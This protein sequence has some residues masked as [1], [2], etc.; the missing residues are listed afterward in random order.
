M[1]ARVP[2][3]RTTPGGM[4]F[5][6]AIAAVI[7]TLVASA[8]LSLGLVPG[9]PGAT[10]ARAATLAEIAADLRTDFVY[11]DYGAENAFTVSETANLALQI[12]DSGLPIFVAV[13]PQAA[14]DAAGGPDALLV[15]IKDAVGRSGVYAVLAGSSFRAG[16]TDVSV[17]ALAERAFADNRAA[18]P[19]A[20]VQAFVDDVIATYGTDSGSAAGSS[21]GSTGGSPIPALVILGVIAAIIGTIAVIAIRRGR[22]RRER[23]LE[24]LRPLLDE[25]ITALGERL[26]AFDTTDP[27]LDD[28]GRQDLQVA[29]DAYAS[30]S[31][32]ASRIRASTDVVAT[33]RSLDNGRYALSCVEARLA[34]APIP[35]RRA[36]CFFDPRHGVSL[37]D[38]RWEPPGG[39]AHPVPAC[40][41]CLVAVREGSQP[42][43]RE[44]E[45]DGAR[46][47]YWD[48]DAT[49]APYARGYF[50]DFQ[51]TMAGAFTGTLIAQ[52]LIGSAAAP[53]PAH[54]G[55]ATT[56]AATFGVGEGPSSGGSGGGDFGGGDFGG[57]F[58]GGGFG[59][60]DFGGG[61]SGGGDF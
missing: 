19:Y 10:P 30:A 5:G 3:P 21:T 24:R 27:R 54:P 42:R 35:A 51:T 11:N 50:G 15:D 59:G 55:V 60:G 12:Q 8:A 17:S 48:A 4:T 31:D 7:T 26:G 47:P 28:A 9:L 37:D 20:V 40:A 25:D 13:L 43:A 36:P 38:V 34:G 29:L 57:D 58:G 23:A 16:G 52:A 46:R 61:G 18:G 32:R 33:V 45:V 39:V 49:Y 1:R 2:L 56:G 53:N 44:V 41:E 22:Q 14:A 6:A